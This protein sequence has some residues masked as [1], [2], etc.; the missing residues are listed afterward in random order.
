MPSFFSFPVHRHPRFGSDWLL[1]APAP[2]RP[3][4][5][6]ARPADLTRTGRGCRLRR[7]VV[8]LTL[9]GAGDDARPV[10]GARGP[11]E[12]KRARRI[13]ERG[14]SVVCVPGR[15][16][17]GGGGDCCSSGC[18]TGEGRAAARLCRSSRVGYRIG[19]LVFP[20]VDAPRGEGGGYL[21]V[22]L[23]GLLS[24]LFPVSSPPP[25]DFPL[26]WAT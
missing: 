23:V 12:P 9:V 3:E 19:R 26:F 14:R 25:P 6:R 15:F 7:V 4:R 1:P 5:L 11:Q 16:S 2:A 22:G 24:F 18:R 20:A 17:H 21:R 8:A 13:L 10:K